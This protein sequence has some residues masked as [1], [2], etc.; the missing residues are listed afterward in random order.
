[1]DG[2]AVFRTQQI[3]DGFEIG[4]LADEGGGNEVD[5]VG[6]SPVHDVVNVL[7]RDGRKVHN[8]AGQVHVLALAQHGSVLTAAE[9]S[10]ATTRN[11]GG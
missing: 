7:L 8:H 9:D 6:H 4:T 5:P 11:S 10:A 3:A 1:M 2:L